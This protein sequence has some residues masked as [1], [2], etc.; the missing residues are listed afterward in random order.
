[1]KGFFVALVVFA[2]LLVA[3]AVQAQTVP[4]VPIFSPLRASLAVGADYAFYGGKDAPA[5]P[6]KKEWQSGIFAGYKLTP[7]LS[8]IAA[9]R[10]GLDSKQFDTKLGL[11]LILWSGTGGGVIQ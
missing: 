1:M 10:Y 3:T 4:N 5:F 9:T 7:A 8:L 6:V 2:A 11:R